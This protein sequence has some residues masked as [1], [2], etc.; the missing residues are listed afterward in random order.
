MGII[1][2]VTLENFLTIAKTLL[3][4]V[5]AIH[6]LSCIWIGLGFVNYNETDSWLVQKRICGTGLN[7]EEVVDNALTLTEFKF[8]IYE[9]ARVI[10][11]TSFY[12]VST[13]TTTVGY[14]DISGYNNTEKFYIMLLEFFGISLFSIILGNISNLQ[15][16]RQHD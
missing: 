16:Q 5:I 15:T 10:Y 12:F 13:T 2:K 11:F 4:L 7:S 9:E 1:S 8:C 14:G 6:M 3:F